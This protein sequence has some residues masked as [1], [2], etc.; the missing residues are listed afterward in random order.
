MSK[1]KIVNPG[2]GGWVGEWTAGW[3]AEFVLYILRTAI[4]KKFWTFN[5]NK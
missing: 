1:F 4:N 3:L 2:V 5:S